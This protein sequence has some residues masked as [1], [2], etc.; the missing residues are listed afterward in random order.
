MKKNWD[1]TIA[2]TKIKFYSEN[3][4]AGN[5]LQEGTTR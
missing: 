2:T 5:N 3:T 4:E 1:A